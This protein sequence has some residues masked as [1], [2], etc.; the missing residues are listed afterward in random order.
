MLLLLACTSRAPVP[1]VSFREAYHLGSPPTQAG[2]VAGPRGVQASVAGGR[3]RGWFG[4]DGTA[5]LGSDLRVQTVG[6]GRG[7]GT[8]GVDTAMPTVG[9]CGGQSCVTLVHVGF[10]E[11]WTDHG[12]GFEQSWTIPTRPRGV[13]DLV[14]DLSVLG[15]TV[16]LVGADATVQTTQQAWTLA[17]LRAWDADGVTLQSRFEIRAGGL[18]IAVVDAGARYPV[19]VDPVYSTPDYELDGYPWTVAGGGDANG[20]GYADIVG[21]GGG[22]FGRGYIWVGTVSGIGSTPAT[23]LSGLDNSNSDL[24]PIGFAGD[25]DGDGYDEVIAVAADDQRVYV[26]AGSSTGLGN[27]PDPTWTFSEGAHHPLWASVAGAGDVNADGYADIVIGIP[28]PDTTQAGRAKLLLGS[29]SGPVDDETSLVL[30]GSGSGFGWAVGAAGDVNGDG[31]DDIVIG[32]GGP[33]TPVYYGSASGVSADNLTMIDTTGSESVACAGELNGDG[34]DD[35]V[36]GGV[37]APDYRGQARLFHGAAGG[38]D[39]EPA[40]IRDGVSDADYYGWSIAG[41]G[42]VNGDGYDDVI[43]GSHTANAEVFLGSPSGLATEPAAEVRFEAVIWGGSVST[44]GDI[45]HDG[46]DDVVV[47]GGYVYL[48][49][50]FLDPTQADSPDD[51]GDADTDSDGDSD[52]DADSDSDS[53][54]DTDSDSAPDSVPGDSDGGAD[55]GGDP[56]GCGGAKRGCSSSAGRSAAPLDLLAMVALDASRRRSRR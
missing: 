46:L 44:A 28:D 41:A 39:P 55:G 25:V 24:V 56:A 48:A 36:V 6:L 2:F 29:A 18:R 27:D 8:A 32:A 50:T 19:T 15:G 23:L 11:S 1:G 20:D 9:D 40:W 4:K 10:T 49:S 42:D 22:A 35:V 31:Y 3:L 5:R 37:N 14:V 7:V 21:S 47:A 16:R 30:E 52:T 26:W 43:V 17:G 53:D 45:D 34:Y 13:G 54:S 33:E 38:V 51:S 12:D